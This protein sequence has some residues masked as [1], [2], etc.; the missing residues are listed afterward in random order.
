MRRRIQSPPRLG[1]KRRTK[2][3]FHYAQSAMPL[4]INFCPIVLHTKYNGS[5]K[6]VRGHVYS[7]CSPKL[8]IH[9][10]YVSGKRAKVLLFIFPVLF[11]INSLQPFSFKKGNKVSHINSIL[12]IATKP[13]NVFMVM[14]F[15]R[16]F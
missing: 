12:K 3:K 9:F 15:V 16:I 8:N 6:P 1:E 4:A 14:Y 2:L 10:Y 13:I 5:H 11:F 7:A